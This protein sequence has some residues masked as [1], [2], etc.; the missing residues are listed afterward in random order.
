MLTGVLLHFVSAGINGA[1]GAK[2]FIYMTNQGIALLVVHYLVYAGVVVGRRVGAPQP[3]A[4]LPPLYSLSWGLQTAFTPVALWITIIYWTALHP[5]VVEFGLV[6]GAWNTFLN[7]FLHLINSLSCL[8][9]LCLTARPLRVHHSYLPVLFGFWYAL[10]S[11][12]YWAA[13]GTGLCI[14]RCDLDPSC[15]VHCDKYIYPILDWE[16][17]PG[18]AVGIVLGGCML[19]PVIVALLCGLT[20]LRDRLAVKQ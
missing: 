6:V 20:W 12:V 18:M 1:M 14:P 10:F 15:A 17:K 5:T 2:W 19:M 9:D 16:D 11:L 4:S 8:L 7:I 3:L 13:G